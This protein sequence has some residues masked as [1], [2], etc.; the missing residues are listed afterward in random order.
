LIDARDFISSVMKAIGIVA[1]ALFVVACGQE[2]ESDHCRPH[3]HTM[4][5]K[6]ALDCNATIKEINRRLDRIEERLKI[7][8]PD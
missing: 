3:G 2:N 7:E 5:L 6:Q 1:I 4:D 8:R